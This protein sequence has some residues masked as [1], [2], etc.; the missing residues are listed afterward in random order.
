[1]RIEG[2][3]I[4]RNPRG[5]H[6]RAA[7]SVVKIASAFRSKITLS[8]DDQEVNAKSVM[9]VL[10]L[11]GACGTG[12]TVIAEGDDATEAVAKLG[13]FLECGFDQ[14]PLAEPSQ[15]KPPAGES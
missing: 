11:C 4:V 1:M 8:R 9:G 15:G 10:L 14:L 2:S 6:A 5:L 12:I 7:A 3:F 13:A